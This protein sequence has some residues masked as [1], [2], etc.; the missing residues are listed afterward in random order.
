MANELEKKN[1]TCYRNRKLQREICKMKMVGGNEIIKNWVS[2]RMVTYILVKIQR[3]QMC[4]NID[5]QVC[6]TRDSLTKLLQNFCSW[7]F[8]SLQKQHFLNYQQFL[9][10]LLKLFDGFM[11]F[12]FFFFKL[13]KGLTIKILQTT[14]EEFLVFKVF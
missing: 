12:W 10:K 9:Q 4:E 14:F 6:F 8:A 5:F 2:S 13:V 11:I 1:A 3:Q 7:N